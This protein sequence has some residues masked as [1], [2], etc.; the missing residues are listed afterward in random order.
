MRSRSF[1]P[2]SPLPPHI[3][4]TA[5]SAEGKH[6]SPPGSRSGSVGPLE[7]RRGDP[8]APSGP[9]SETVQLIFAVFVEL[10]NRPGFRGLVQRVAIR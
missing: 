6:E 3:E 4:C 9:C 5:R 2:A 8:P 1:D 10:L 7:D